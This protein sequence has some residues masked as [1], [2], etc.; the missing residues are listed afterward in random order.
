MGDY[1]PGSRMS[2]VHVEIDIDPET[3][4][5]TH[6]GFSFDVRMPSGAIHTGAGGDIWHTGSAVPS[7]PVREMARILTEEWIKPHAQ[8]CGLEVGTTQGESSPVRPLSLL[9]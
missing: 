2:R 7:Q 9:E 8:D 1:A 5:V 6:C 3:L 4:E